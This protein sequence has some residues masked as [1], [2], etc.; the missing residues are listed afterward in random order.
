[1]QEYEKIDKSSTTTTTT[2]RTED[3][4]AVKRA[5]ADAGIAWSK[6]A[7]TMVTRW[8]D[9]VPAAVIIDYAISE[10]AFAPYPSMRYVAAIMKR[11]LAS[12]IKTVAE[13]RGTE[14]RRAAL[15]RVPAQDY[16][17][18]DYSNE[19]QELPSW[20]MARWEEMQKQ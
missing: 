7:E 18:R 8:L 16:E 12:G 5:A 1:M 20:M 2:R 10:T 14:P 11:L 17:Q 6:Q 15:A 19:E 13:A 4:Q 9:L 3:V